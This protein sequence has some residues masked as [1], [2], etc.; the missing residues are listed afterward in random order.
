MSAIKR[1]LYSSPRA[2]NSA[3]TSS[4]G[5]IFND[6]VILI[7][8]LFHTLFDSCHIIQGKRTWHPDVVVKPSSMT[9][10]ITI[11]ASGKSC[12]TACPTRCAQEWRIIS[13]PSSSFGVIIC[14]VESSVI[15]SHASTKRSFTRPATVFLLD[16]AQYFGQLP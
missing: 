8:E 9:G 12:L 11:L 5:V 7:D 16:Q 1:N 15:K 13:R 3:I 14:K 6:I 10:P 4:R 2:V